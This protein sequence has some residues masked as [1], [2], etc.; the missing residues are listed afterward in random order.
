MSYRTPFPGATGGYTDPGLHPQLVGARHANA[1]GEYR[2]AGFLA[3]GLGLAASHPSAALGVGATDK[4]HN[5]V[6]DGHRG[7]AIANHPDGQFAR[8]TAATSDHS[9]HANSENTPFL[10]AT[11]YTMDART[12]ELDI[13][14]GPSAL[15]PSVPSSRLEQNR[16][17]RLYDQPELIVK[18]A[19]ATGMRTGSLLFREY[20]PEELAVGAVMLYAAYSAVA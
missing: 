14:T 3:P 8:N 18:R 6:L 9:L 10:G 12:M 11:G 16:A 5:S 20:T 17:D 4:S 13:D 1:G 19:T 15:R 2:S 7:S